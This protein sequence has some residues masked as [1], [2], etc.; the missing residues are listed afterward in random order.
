MS[1]A[2]RSRADPPPNS[3]FNAAHDANVGLDLELRAIENALGA[4]DALPTALSLS[5][6][7]S[8]ELILSGRL[9]TLLSNVDLSTTSSPRPETALHTSRAPLH[10]AQR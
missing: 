9:H 10:S 3:W 7:S 8:P 6:N 2:L 1:R 5:V 4:L